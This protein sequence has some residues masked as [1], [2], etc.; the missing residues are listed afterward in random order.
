MYTLG[1]GVLSTVSYSRAITLLT[2][3][4][5]GSHYSF[6]FER[7]VHRGHQPYA[8]ISW[9][10]KLLGSFESAQPASCPVACIA[11]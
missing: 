1:R 7:S 9:A 5:G 11:W 4:G 10:V 3:A 2:R 6:R 8:H